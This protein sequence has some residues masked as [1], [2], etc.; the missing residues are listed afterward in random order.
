MYF[1]ML[2]NYKIFASN[3]LPSQITITP[4]MFNYDKIKRLKVG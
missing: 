1:N 4:F 2:Q 3:N